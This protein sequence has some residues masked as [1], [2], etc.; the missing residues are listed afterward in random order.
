MSLVHVDDVVGMAL[1]AVK[2]PAISG[3][4]NAVMPRAVRNAD[5]T[6]EL[7]GAL[8]RPAIFPVP[9]PVLRLALGGLSEL[10]L[11][12]LRVR[13]SAALAGGYEF[14]HPSLPA[15]LAASL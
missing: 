15:A 4:L 11:A 14:R 13:P 6:K 5:F 10:M 9:G 8:G 2:N 12:S 1:W 3:A 7:A